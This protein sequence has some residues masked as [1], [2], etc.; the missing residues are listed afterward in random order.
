MSEPAPGSLAS[1]VEAAATSLAGVTVA[2]EPGS[3]TL[4]RADRPFAV[5]RGA[6]LSVRLTG[7]LA[8]AAIRTPDTAPGIDGEG[9]VDFTP[10]AIDQ[11]AA[12]RATSWIEAAWRR[13]A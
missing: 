10:P 8:R 3:T 1:I 12:D 2:A 13:A 5:L 11:Y 7:E 4:R 6:T 9:W